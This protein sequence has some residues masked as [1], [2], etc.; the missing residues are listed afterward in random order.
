MSEPKITRPQAVILIELDCEAV[1]HVTDATLN[2]I[3]DVKIGVD[4]RKTAEYVGRNR[5]EA[6][7]KAA[8]FFD[9]ESAWQK[10]KNDIGMI[11]KCADR[12]DTLES[13][14]L[15]KK[16]HE[17]LELRNATLEKAKRGFE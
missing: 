16:Y 10:A 13:K 1:G 15:I 4:A 9:A 7:Y 14:E 12:F 6:R 17:A 2:L 3:R 5:R 11:L 8:G